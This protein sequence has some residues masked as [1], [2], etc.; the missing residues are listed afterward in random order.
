MPG[1]LGICVSETHSI[2]ATA[3]KKGGIL[4]EPIRGGVHDWTHWFEDINFDY[5]CKDTD[6]TVTEKVKVFF[7][8]RRKIV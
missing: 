5:T 8:V 7:D 6:I 4:K 1:H 2:E 3:A